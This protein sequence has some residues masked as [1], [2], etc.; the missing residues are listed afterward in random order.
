[1]FGTTKTDDFHQRFPTNL[2]YLMFINYFKRVTWRQESLVVVNDRVKEVGL[3]GLHGAPGW[4]AVWTECVNVGPGEA[5]AVFVDDDEVPHAGVAGHVGKVGQKLDGKLFQ[6][7]ERVAAG[8]GKINDKTT[9][10]SKYN[11]QKFQI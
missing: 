3:V 11:G 4:S 1:M 8:S 6:K 10:I 7:S 5:R 2:P 9:T